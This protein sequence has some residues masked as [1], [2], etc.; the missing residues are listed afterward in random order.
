MNHSLDGKKIIITGG[1]SGIGQ[2][3]ALM[4]AE[5]GADIAL[6]GL[7]EEGAEKTIQGIRKFGKNSFFQVFDI[8]DLNAARKFVND[9]INFLGGLDGL[10]NN[11]GTN[12]WHGVSNAT[13]DQI[14]R[15][16]DVNF[17][18]AW[19]I[20]QE[21]YPALKDNHGGV[22]VNM[23]SIHAERTLPG[24]FPYNV[25]KAA[26]VA[27]TKSMA[28][29]WG[30]DN[31]QALAIQPALIQTPLAQEYFDKFEDPKAE[32]LRLESHYPLGRSGK[33]EDIASLVVFLLSKQNKFISGQSILVDGA[34]SV[35]M[36]SPD[37]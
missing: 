37:N 8:G 28:L 14:Q 11:A 22:I 9:S 1:T 31:I 15:C 17:Y 4:A 30:K 26:M 29:E 12:F 32:L 2:A 20:S 34:I 18:S 23:S 27:M 6:C 36:E 19:A 21:A 35:L 5:A 24:V 16:M 13:I 7:N 3:T 10:F 33:P 25:S